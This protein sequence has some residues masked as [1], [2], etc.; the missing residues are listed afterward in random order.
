MNY[1]R[2]INETIEFIED[3]LN[4]NIAVDELA[5]CNYISKFYFTR[6]FKALTEKNIKEYIDG[7]KMSEAA[8]RLKMSSGRIIDVALDYGFES[9]ETFT[10]K[11]LLY[12]I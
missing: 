5:K 2:M 6:I 11:F 7:R 9:H 1:F 4:R 10:R 3:N 8:K 12:P